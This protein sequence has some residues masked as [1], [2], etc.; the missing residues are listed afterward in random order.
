MID[1]FYKKV[2]DEAR[3]YYLYMRADGHVSNDEEKAFGDI[4]K[5]LR[6]KAEDQKEIISECEEL[7][8]DSTEVLEVIIREKIDKKAKRWIVSKSAYSLLKIIWNLINLGYADKVYSENKK[9]IVDYLVR[10]WN[11]KEEIYQEM[12]DTA[13]TIQALRK[14]KEWIDKV[15]QN[16]Y[17]RDDK[18]KRIDV[19]IEKMLSDLK[20]TI[21]E[22]IIRERFYRN[23]I[24]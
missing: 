24:S 6:I 7:V 9:E 14:Q 19:E 22:I 15:I 10:K 21:D 20:L 3:L 17:E 18:I 5:K 16:D 23:F 11:V 1:Y 13:N 8:K 4:C 2:K 12:L